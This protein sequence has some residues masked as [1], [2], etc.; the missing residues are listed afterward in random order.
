MRAYKKTATAVALGL[1]LVAC[2]GGGGGG[3][4]APANPQAATGD[5]TAGAYRTET[6]QALEPLLL[7][8]AF[9]GTVGTTRPFASDE[10]RARAAAA[11]SAG[12]AALQTGGFERRL[13]ERLLARGGRV[14]ALATESLGSSACTDGGSLDLTV[15]YADPQKFTPGDR[16]VATSN[17]CVED[18]FAIGGSFSLVLSEFRESASSISVKARIVADQF[19]STALR[20]DGTGRIALVMNDQAT[21]GTVSIT[22]D[23]MSVVAGAK[24]FVWDHGYTYIYDETGETFELGGYVA[25]NDRHYRIRQD[26]TFVVDSGGTLMSGRISLFDKDGDRV[27]VDAFSGSSTYTFF[28]AGNAT[29]VGSVA[30]LPLGN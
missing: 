24:Q 22:Y 3:D 23:G 19:G 30:G 29:P 15:T 4:D 10:S 8:F 12:G 1:T 27:Q 13:A 6:D 20:I 18:G 25:V 14:Q 16:I 21:A 26:Q 11:G 2:G 5:F 28:V 7:A 9:E 17:A